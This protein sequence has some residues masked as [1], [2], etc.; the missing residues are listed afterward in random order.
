MTLPPAYFDDLYAAAD[1]PWSLRTRWYERR[2]YAL[3]AAALPREQYGDGLEVGCSVGE[4]TAVLAPRC[5][6]MTAWDAS[7][8]AVATAAARN[9]GVAVERRVAPRDRL[10]VVDLLVLSEVLY[11][12]A[13]SDLAVLVEQVRT[14]VRPGGT[15][16][17]VHWRHPVADYPQTGDAVHAALR[18]ALDWP[19]VAAH[20]EP[21]L[22]LDC[23]VRAAAGDGRAASVAAAEDLW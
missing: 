6:R 17:A 19:R 9:P 22:L 8:A 5:A 3:S 21:D 1:D 13:P 11:Y 14:A 16:L 7:A 15:L 2:K 20:E 10:P 12:L 23:W 18:T 4:L